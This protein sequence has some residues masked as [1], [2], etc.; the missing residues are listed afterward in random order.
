M[1][2]TGKEQQV[3]VFNYFQ[4]Q[5]AQQHRELVKSAGSASNYFKAGQR[6]RK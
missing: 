2:G 3:S 4:S 5:Q 6:K 1:K